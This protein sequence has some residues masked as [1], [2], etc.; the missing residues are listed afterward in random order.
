MRERPLYVYVMCIIACMYIYRHRHMYDVA[1]WQYIG[2]ELLIYHTVYIYVCVCVL[3][4]TDCFVVSQLF[5]V[6]RH[7]RRSKSESKPA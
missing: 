7:T 4:S 6:A 1:Y 2:P 3:S 5:S